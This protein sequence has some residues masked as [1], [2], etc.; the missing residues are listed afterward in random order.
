MAHLDQAW[1]LSTTPVVYAWKCLWDSSQ[2]NKVLSEFWENC[3]A[4]YMS[5]SD[6]NVF[7]SVTNIH[8]ILPHQAL[9]FLI[10]SLNWPY[11]LSL[12]TVFIRVLRCQ[13]QT[14]TLATLDR[15][16]IY[17]KAITASRILGGTEEPSWEL[18]SSIPKCRLLRKPGVAWLN[19]MQGGTHA[20]GSNPSSLRARCDSPRKRWCPSALRQGLWR[21]SE[22]EDLRSCRKDT[23]AI[24]ADF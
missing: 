22:Q 9:S 11:C 17:E 15:K 8:L 3:H 14:Q 18:H 2:L 7:I 16:G 5:C 21:W 24:P 23:L 20:V 19:R 1:W 6:L 4:R 13:Q 12:R 10:A